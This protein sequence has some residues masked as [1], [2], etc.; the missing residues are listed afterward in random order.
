MSPT[1]G[2]AH[3]LVNL[4]LDG[5]LYTPLPFLGALNLCDGL[6]AVGYQ[7]DQTLSRKLRKCSMCCIEVQL[8]AAP[9]SV[10]K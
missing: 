3:R 1:L 8:R 2:R 6:N 4:G 9:V 7:P 10:V 5:E